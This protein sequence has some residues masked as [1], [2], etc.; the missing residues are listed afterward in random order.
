MDPAFFEIMKNLSKLFQNPPTPL[1][2][3]RTNSYVIS[4]V[5]TPDVEQY[6]TAIIDEY[7]S[8][9]VERYATE[10]L[11]VAGHEHWMQVA[12]QLTEIV[13]LGLPEVIE[14]EKVTLVPI[15]DPERR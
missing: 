12:D 8:H 6:E 7:K 11:A 15:S 2:R 9:P 5:Y 13:K 10:E 3:D 1:R 14:A 4:T